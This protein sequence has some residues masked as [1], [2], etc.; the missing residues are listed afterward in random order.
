[1]DRIDDELTRV[2][3]RRMRLSAEIAR[4]KQSKR[5][6]LYD[7]ARE[8][9]VLA[10]AVSIC[11]EGMEHYAGCLYRTL[12][13]ASRSYQQQALAADALAEPR[14]AGSRE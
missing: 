4:Y 2:F 9:E 7:P 13:A 3:V 10:K 14:G 11:G 6:P 12:F 1:M 8:R 5:L